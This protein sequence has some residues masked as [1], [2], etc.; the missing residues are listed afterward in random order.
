MFHFVCTS[1]Y[2]TFPRVKNSNEIKLILIR[3]RLHH[4]F[5]FPESCIQYEYE[6][7]GITYGGLLFFYHIL[8]H[9][10]WIKTTIRWII[11]ELPLKYTFY[12]SHANKLWRIVFVYYVHWSYIYMI[13]NVFYVFIDYT[14]TMMMSIF[15]YHIARCVPTGQLYSSIYLTQCA[16]KIRYFVIIIICHIILYNKGGQPKWV[17]RPHWKYIT[18]LRAIYTFILVFCLNI[19]KKLELTF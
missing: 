1:K 10:S 5:L 11:G 4:N 6:Y 3:D 12:N 18:I 2:C 14:E 17:C 15:S 19:K 16:R 13:L 7:L 8:N 9:F